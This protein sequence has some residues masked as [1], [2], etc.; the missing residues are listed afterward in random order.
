MTDNAENSTIHWT[1]ED[2]G[3]DNNYFLAYNADDADTEMQPPNASQSTV[4]VAVAAATAADDDEMEVAGNQQDQSNVNP[5]VIVIDD[6]YDNDDE[7]EVV[8]DQQDQSNVTFVAPESKS[9]GTSKS[10]TGKCK[11]SDV[12]KSVPAVRTNPPPCLCR[13]A[14]D[15]LP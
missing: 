13:H 10:A 15:C 7:V 5:V 11:L 14:N 6:D 3:S 4:A 12:L 2:M 1:D 8:G 9:T